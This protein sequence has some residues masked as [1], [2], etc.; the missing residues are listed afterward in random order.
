VLIPQL[1]NSDEFFIDGANGDDNNYRIGSEWGKKEVKR[2]D[3][4]NAPA[5][6]KRAALA[7]GKLGGGT[8]FYLGK[9]AGFHLIATNHHVC[10]DLMSCVMDEETG[11]H[12]SIYFPL[13]DQKY[14]VLKSF[15]TWPEIDLSILAIK[16]PQ[17]D[18]VKIQ[19]LGR[20]FAFNKHFYRGQKLLTLGFGI[21]FNRQR[22]LT[23]GQD[24]DCVV[25]SGDDEFR[26]LA[27]PDTMNPAPYKAWSFSH[28]CDTSHGDSG[29]SVV[30][31]ETGE[32]LGIVWTAAT[33]K[34]KEVLDSNYLQTLLEHP[35]DKA[36]WTRLAY[37]VPAAAMGSY[38]KHLLKTGGA[39]HETLDVLD[40]LL[41]A[42]AQHHAR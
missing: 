17:E 24:S 26:L 29:S 42:S 14:E 20:S 18:D 25:F 35:N 8:A 3:L 41:A 39:P 10:P 37:G 11:I 7:T 40:A 13:I 28:G 30:D 5:G 23:G 15:G 12:Y 9:F 22:V 33:P 34:A 4:Q 32:L 31:R 38:F 21:A 19:K 2:S 36:I 27:D 1:A 6:F 16:V